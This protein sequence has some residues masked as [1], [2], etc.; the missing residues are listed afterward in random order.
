MSGGNPEIQPGWCCE[1]YPVL[2]GSKGV[3]PSLEVV[4]WSD[5]VPSRRYP[6]WAVPY[7]KETRTACSLVVSERRNGGRSMALP[8]G[9]TVAVG[10]GLME[11]KCGVR[12]L[13]YS[14]R[15]VGIWG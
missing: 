1:A 9:C 8:G 15:V 14:W 6:R 10:N 3:L 2:T 7:N 4:V 5:R 11:P 12:C 13:P